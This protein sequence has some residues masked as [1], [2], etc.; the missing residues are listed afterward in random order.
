MQV[1]PSVRD[2][3]AIRTPKATLSSSHRLGAINSCQLLGRPLLARRDVATG[4]D[5]ANVSVQFNWTRQ[6]CVCARDNW[7]ATASL[8]SQLGSLWPL[9]RISFIHEATNLQLCCRASRICAIIASH[10][11]SVCV[12]V[13]CRVVIVEIEPPSLA[14]SNRSQP[15]DPSARSVAAV[16]RLLMRGNSKPLSPRSRPE[17]HRLA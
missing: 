15:F 4:H 11:S 7:L 17:R 8:A 5:K 6:S 14:H 16:A 1:A 9:R 13:S 10:P 3:H 2:K 12:C